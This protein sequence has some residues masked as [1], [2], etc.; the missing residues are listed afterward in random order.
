MSIGCWSDGPIRSWSGAFKSFCTPIR[1]PGSE[2]P[3]IL[4]CVTLHLGIFASH[5]GSNLQA[6][7]DAAANG[8]IDA[9]PV[10]VISNNSNSAALER[11]RSAGVAT[12]HLS[13]ATH[14][15]PEALDRALV[16]TLRAHGVDLVVLAGYMRQLGPQ[17]IAAYRNRILNIHPALL[18]KHGGAGFYGERVHTAVLAA[19]DTESGATVHLVDEEYDHGASLAQAKVPV[20]ADDTPKALADRVLAVE[21][22]LYVETIGRIAAGDLALPQ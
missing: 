9:V 12:A 11:A 15:E 22:K 5:G 1:C 10:V 16:E 8:T 3:T 21:H 14:G 13:M 17:T 20:L 18:P 2:A 6:I 19:G 4:A 7:L